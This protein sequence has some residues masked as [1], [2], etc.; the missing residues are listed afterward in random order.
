MFICIY[1]HEPSNMPLKGLSIYH[2]NTR[3][4]LNKITLLQTLYENVEILCCSETW[5]DNRVLDR[6]IE[7]PGKTVFRCDRHV[8]VNDYMKRVFGGGVCIYV[9]E[10]F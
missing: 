6:I 1:S 5:L 7:I 3:S 9:G 2:V 8:N 4:I 10:F